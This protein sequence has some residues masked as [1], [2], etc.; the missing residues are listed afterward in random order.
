MALPL[1]VEDEY[2]DEGDDDDVDDVVQ[3]LVI[4]LTIAVVSFVSALAPLKLIHLGAHLFSVGR[5]FV[6]SGN[7]PSTW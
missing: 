3:K 7:V 4:A 1:L 6:V 5:N 2:D